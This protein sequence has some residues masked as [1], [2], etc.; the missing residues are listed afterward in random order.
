MSELAELR[1]T[2]QRAM[3][4]E[5]AICLDLAVGVYRQAAGLISLLEEIQR[6]AKGIVTDIMIET[7]QMDVKTGG[8]RA[9]ITKPSVSVRYD[10]KGLDQL[11]VDR[12]DLAPV[13]AVHRIEQERAGVLTIR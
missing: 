9:Y 13:L 7:T 1:S 4:G 3:V 10:T 5:P 12:P 2:L 6:E 8:G 11:L